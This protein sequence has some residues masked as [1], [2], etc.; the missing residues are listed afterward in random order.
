M[1]FVASA[2]L[3]LFWNSHPVKDTH[4]PDYVKLFPEAIAVPLVFKHFQ[5]AEAIRLWKFYKGEC[6][7]YPA[8]DPECERIRAKVEVVLEK[9][10][11]GGRNGAD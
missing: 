11:K 10:G 2:L 3:Y 9:I 6:E 5:R 1:I 7:K 4:L 8:G